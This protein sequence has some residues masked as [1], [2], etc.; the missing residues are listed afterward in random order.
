[1]TDTDIYTSADVA[2]MVRNL[3]ERFGGVERAAEA[4]FVQPSYISNV[5]NGKC[6]P[7]PAI[8]DY[9]GLRKESKGIFVSTI[10]AELEE[11]PNILKE[12]H[13]KKP[14]KRDPMKLLRMDY[15][16]LKLAGKVKIPRGRGKQISTGSDKYSYY[17]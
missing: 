3:V 9:F 13:D 1:M 15:V 7:G 17:D 2:Q 5:K 14:I 12:L 4:M 8:L 6:A 10:G 11:E 16:E